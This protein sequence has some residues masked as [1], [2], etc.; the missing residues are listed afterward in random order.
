MME[1][2]VNPMSEKAKRPPGVR[3]AGRNEC[4]RKWQL[5]QMCEAKC[6]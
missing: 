2:K 6:P 4:A 1:L 5:V 3:A